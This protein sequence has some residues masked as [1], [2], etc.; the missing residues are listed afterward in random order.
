MV[1]VGNG[2]L[3]RFLHDRVQWKTSR[4]GTP[5][6]SRLLS[7]SL[8][9]PLCAFGSRP[10][11][12]FVQVVDAKQAEGERGAE[13]RR[14]EVD[15]GDDARV[16]RARAVIVAVQPSRLWAALCALASSEGESSLGTRC[17]RES[18]LDEALASSAPV[19]K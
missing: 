12:Q 19:R 18:W 3:R 1:V 2:D 13:Q 5:K 7:A 11:L 17:I 4:I 8:V 14:L 10:A 15:D 6:G 9:L 16:A